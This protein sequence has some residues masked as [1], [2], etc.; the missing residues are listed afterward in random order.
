MLMVE[1]AIQVT[2]PAWAVVQPA[3][4]AAWAM[5]AKGMA[6]EDDQP[7][8]AEEW[9]AAQLKA[10]TARLAGSVAAAMAAALCPT[11]DAAREAMCRTPPFGMWAMAVTSMS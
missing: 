2:E 9:E 11:S 8:L 6:W 7:V 1:E 4:T 10:K 3:F 5:E